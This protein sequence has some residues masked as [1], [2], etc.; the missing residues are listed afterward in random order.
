MADKPRDAKDAKPQQ[1]NDEI[2]LY[3]AM[4]LGALVVALPA[5]VGAGMWWL[6]RGRLRKS[7]FIIM[8]VTAAV[9]LVIAGQTLFGG[10]FAWLGVL[11]T[12]DGNRADVP[13][14][15]IVLMGALLA[16]LAALLEGTR[17]GA[18]LPEKIFRKKDPFAH[19]SVLPSESKRQR[20][21]TVT[22]PGDLLVKAEHHSIVNPMKVG[23]R[24]FPIGTDGNGVPFMISEDEI[25]T[26]G[27]LFG[28]TGS[29]KTITIEALAGGLMDLGWEGMI[30]DLK[31]DTDTGGLR[32][33][34]WDY[35]MSH[36]KPFQQLCLSD[37]EPEF[38]FNPLAGI[39]PDEARDAILSLMEFEAPY[40]RAIN[41]EMLGQLTSLLYWVHEVDPVKFPYPTTIEMGKILKSGA[42]DTATKKMRAIVKTSVPGIDDDYFT[43]L[44]HPSKDEAQSATGLGSR[45]TAMYATQAGRTILKADPSRKLLDVTQGGLTYVGLDSQGKPDLTR[46]ISS[47]VLQRLSVYA[48]MRTTG[49]ADGKTVPR[50]LIVDEANWVDRTI[51]QNLL[52]RARGAGIAMI[53]A[54]QGPKDWIDR[55]GDDFAKL[56][57][58]TNV[59]IIMSQGEPE[60]AEICA[61]YIGKEERIDV[62]RKVMDG[63]VFDMGTTRKET[64]HRVTPDQLRSLQIGEAVIRIGKPIE[65]FSWVAVGRRDPR[66]APGR[67]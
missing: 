10:Y 22:P 40:W 5:M 24:S 49:R 32:D 62:S 67:R 27:L 11:L 9:G 18:K 26:H 13:W 64:V 63:D 52:S 66:S 50:F 34:C 1:N 4:A 59:A 47:S 25:R 56:G 20:A 60:S 6:L 21:K 16:A 51:V 12:G 53:L 38:W 65:R 43:S 48:S 30:L 3:L 35:S 41:E 2:W 31:E 14:L 28:S 8:A 57:Q 7:E 45:L 61:D 44:A 58:N 55:Q 39:G 54:T 23:E 17:I 42:L 19:D 37:A 46:V 15:S 36:A 33:W 29:G